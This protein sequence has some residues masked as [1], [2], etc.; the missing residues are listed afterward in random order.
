MTF[1]ALRP[2]SCHSME[3]PPSGSPACDRDAAAAMRACSGRSQD[4]ASEL[5]RLI[6]TRR[7][8][9]R[10]AVRNFANMFRGDGAARL[11]CFIAQ[12]RALL[13]GT[14]HVL[15]PRPRRL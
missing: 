5:G 11:G 1:N 7:H 6:S 12:K 4:A 2:I 3:K 13:Q 8:P 15:A 9:L 10:M 14:K